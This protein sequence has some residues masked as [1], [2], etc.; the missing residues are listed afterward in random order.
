MPRA[1]LRVT[2]PKALWIGELSREYP[3]TQFRILAAT[4]REIVGVA[5]V[6]IVGENVEAA[7]AHMQGYEE[8][9]AFEALEVHADYGLVQ[10]ETTLPVLLEAAQDAGVPI[11]LPLTL[12]AGTGFWEVTGSRDRLSNLGTSLETFGLSF[13][14]E[15]IYQKVGTDQLLTDEQWELL[16]TAIDLGYYDTLRACTQYELAD[17]VGVARSTC[18]ERLHRAES[19]IIKQFVTDEGVTH[20]A[21]L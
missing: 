9:T 3:A 19:E 17:A 4:P 10:F 13:S 11:A 20:T 6:E 5:L 21:G 12:Q 2:F 1:T 18:S 7:M 15:S 8:V 14:V 16:E